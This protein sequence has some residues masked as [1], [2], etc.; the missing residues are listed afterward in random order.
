MSTMHTHAHTYTQALALMNIMTIQNVI[1]TQLKNG[2]Q[3]EYVF[4]LDRA[5]HQASTASREAVTWAS[6]SPVTAM[7][8][9]TTAMLRLVFAG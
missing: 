8:T 7:V 2:H 4:V 3:H 6:A 5:V 1:D 9:P